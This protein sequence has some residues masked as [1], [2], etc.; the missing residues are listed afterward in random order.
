MRRIDELH[1]DFSYY[2]ACKISAQLVREGHRAG[3]LHVG[4][5]MRLMGI[6]AHD[7]RPR[8]SIPSRENSVYPY[9]LG[10]VTKDW[11]NHVWSADLTYLPMAQGFL[12]LTAIL[13]IFSRKV[14]AFRLSNT[15][16][17]DFCVEALEDSLYRHGDPGIVNTDQ[18]SQYTSAAWIDV[19]KARGI[20]ISTDGK[21]RWVDNVF[22]ERLWR[23]TKYE[24]VFQHAYR[25]GIEARQRLTAYLES[26][27]LRRLPESL[28][29]RTPEEVY[30]DVQAPLPAAA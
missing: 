8:T 19:L 21:R 10:G 26:Y 17:A 11:P 23:S 5:L 13:D 24:A 20:R 4:T 29:Y 27:N 25:D 2:G 15:L 30:R 1:L 7:C 28:S 16:T 3:R 14:L 18:G 12:Y 22:V 6:E 9:L